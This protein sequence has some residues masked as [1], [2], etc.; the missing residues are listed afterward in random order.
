MSS[1]YGRKKRR[2][3]LA[4]IADLEVVER[5]FNKVVTDAARVQAE[6]W[7]LIRELEDARTRLLREFAENTPEIKEALSRI[8]RELFHELG[9]GLRPH[10]EELLRATRHRG[11]LGPVPLHFELRHDRANVLM[12]RITG[13][14]PEL[15][16][17]VVYM[18]GRRR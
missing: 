16:Y 6:N 5:S 9:E 8:T 3:H 2:A 12:E 10:A 4:R 1:R 14:I 18:K 11:T 17:S 13:Y 7:R 15:R